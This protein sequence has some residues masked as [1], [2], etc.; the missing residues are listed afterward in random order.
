MNERING[1]K[2]VTKNLEDTMCWVV[3]MNASAQFLS[4]PTCHGRVDTACIKTEDIGRVV[5][6]RHDKKPQ[7]V[8]SPKQC[9]RPHTITF[10][11]HETHTHM[12]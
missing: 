7:T 6:Y 2:F 5:D 8:M 1:A 10:N 9:A 12:G 4:A 11:P 3:V